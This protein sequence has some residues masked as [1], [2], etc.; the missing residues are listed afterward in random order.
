[1]KNLFITFSLAS[2][3]LLSGCGASAYALNEAA[4]AGDFVHTVTSVEKLDV[5][6]ASY[7]IADFEIIAEDLPADEGFTWIHLTGTVTNNSQE[8]DSLDVTNVGVVD[9]AGNVYDA[10]TDT[11]I[12]VEDGKSPIYIE[13]QPT[14]TID[15]DGYFMVPSTA[16]G[17]KFYGND[18]TFVPESEVY[19]DLGL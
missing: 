2:M 9:S 16:T 19:V 6:P 1:M 15:W 13:I 12:Y 8:S 4:P 18:L 11:T 17:L 5:I 14:Q 10:S 7:T 3:A